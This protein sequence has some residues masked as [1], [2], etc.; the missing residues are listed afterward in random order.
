MNR[1]PHIQLWAS[2]LLSAVAYG[3]FF[4]NV[5]REEFTML[6]LFIAFLFLFYGRLVTEFGK[7]LNILLGAG[8]LFRLMAFTAPVALSEDVYRFLWDGTLVLAGDNP[9]TQLP[10][11]YE[12]NQWYGQGLSSEL[13]AQLNSP[14]Y[15]SVYPPVVQYCSAFV[16][17][18][19]GGDISLAIDVFRGF[20]LSFELLSFF[21]LLRILDRIKVSQ[22]AAF[23]YFLNPL[24][25]IE[26]S[27]NLHFE[28]VV[29]M[30]LLLSFLLILQSRT[31]GAVAALTAAVLTKLNPLMFFPSLLWV[32]KGWKRMLLAK[33]LAV[34]LFVAAFIPFF[35][36]VFWEHLSN[37]LDLYFRNFEFNA[38][39]YFLIRNIWASA[40]G[41]NP[42]HWLGPILS[43]LG[44][45]FILTAIVFR[46]N[47]AVL[48]LPETWLWVYTIY[49]ITAT[50]VHPWYLIPLVLL[51]ALSG[52]MFPFFW[53]ALVFLS[54][55]HYGPA[56]GL[57]EYFVYLEFALVFILMILEL[58][59]KA[60][61]RE[62]NS[63]SASIPE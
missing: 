61:E 18:L 13:Y 42:I 15:Y 55:S 25:I 63:F 53:S 22:S 21:L 1:R 16:V 26:I 23:L 48:K 7:H 31:L 27:G 34:V 33:M 60:A 28:G 29:V 35:S 38:G 4:H 57:Y 43:V 20:F 39:L 11:F 52:Y 24:V 10:C 37:S 8:I 2:I 36:P 56:N 30:F 19:S 9:F 17:F 49:L 51:G 45:L 41:Y 44:F 12:V 14:K 6:I 40:L 47:K 59:W 58:K 46:R 32:I 50:T 54:Y 5:V 62:R 3:Y